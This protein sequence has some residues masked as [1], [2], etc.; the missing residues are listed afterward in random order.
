MLIAKMHANFAVHDVFWLLLLLLLL[1]VYSGLKR[2]KFN[3]NS[4]LLIKTRKK[5]KRKAC[6][7]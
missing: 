1:L 6:D 2:E 7:I 5:I 4:F 3:N